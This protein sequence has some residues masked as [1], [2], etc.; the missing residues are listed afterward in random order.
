MKRPSDS[1]IRIAKIIIGIMIIL[2]W[3][4][5][6]NLQNLSLENSIFGIA[7]DDTSKQYL[8]YAIIWLWVIPIVLWGLDINVLSR[9]RTR[10][11]QIIFWVLLFIISGMFI[12]TA[13]LSVDIFYFLIWLVVFIAWATWKAITKKG[14]KTGQKITKIRV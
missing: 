4:A 2:T 9:G 1:Q 3:I 7:L 11:L 14:L 13:T 5:A 8:S 6:F 12:E 10:I